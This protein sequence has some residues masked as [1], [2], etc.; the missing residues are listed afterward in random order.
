MTHLSVGEVDTIPFLVWS[1][2]ICGNPYSALYTDEKG[3]QEEI[4]P[5]GMMI[6]I[7]ALDTRCPSGTTQSQSA[8]AESWRSVG[9]RMESG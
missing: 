3:K 9:L 2:I 8:T 6:F 5:G 4:Q 7:Q 1:F